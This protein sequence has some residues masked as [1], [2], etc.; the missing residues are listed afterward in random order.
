MSE[1]ISIS[2][3]KVRT[4]RVDDTSLDLGVMSELDVVVRGKVSGNCS[5]PSH[6]V[7]EAE[8]A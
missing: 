6:V 2:N 4:I 7:S 5:R 8:F 3:P 1:R